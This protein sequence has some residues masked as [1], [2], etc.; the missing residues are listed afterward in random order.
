MRCTGYEMAIYKSTRPTVRESDAHTM[1]NEQPLQAEASTILH[2]FN[3][4]H[5]QISYI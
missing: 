3:S 5:T 2:T 1:F 4:F